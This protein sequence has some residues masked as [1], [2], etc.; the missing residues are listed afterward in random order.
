M[1]Y[2]EKSAMRGERERC[3]ASIYIRLVAAGSLQLGDEVAGAGFAHLAALGGD[4]DERVLHVLGHALGVAAHVE[5]RTVPE[6]SP[7]LG[8]GLA[9]AVLHVGFLGPVARPG[10]GE[11]RQ[12]AVREERLQLAP[13]E[14]VGGLVLVA[15][16]QPCAP[17]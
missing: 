6:P 14:K 10:G 2:E 3:G 7:Q 16:E 17:L 9:H 8:S 1:E 12:R 15:E 4:L 13:I 5:M 11:A